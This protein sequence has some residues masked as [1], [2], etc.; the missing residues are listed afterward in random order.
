[1]ELWSLRPCRCHWAM[2]WERVVPVFGAGGVGSADEA[3]TG[4]IF[5]ITN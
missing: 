4:V 1:M 3:D 2:G 5:V